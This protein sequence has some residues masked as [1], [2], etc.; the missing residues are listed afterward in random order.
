MNIDLSTE[1]GVRVAHRLKEE[2]IVWLTTVRPD[3]RP[4]PSPV[5]FYWD[6]STI[7][8]YSQLGKTKVAAIAANSHVA[9]NFDSD[10]TGGDIVVLTGEARIDDTAPPSN[11][12]PEYQVKYKEHIARIGST[13]ERFAKGYPVATRVTPTK[14]R[15]F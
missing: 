7:L 8:I 14:L 12:V 5:W 3:G 4:E 10:T 13:P 11:E 9:L 1:Y 2:I 15:G 6:G